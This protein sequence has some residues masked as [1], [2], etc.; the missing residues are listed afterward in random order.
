MTL[1]SPQD[2]ATM[3]ELRGQIDR[4]D[5][6]L[7]R[8]F[9]LR[10]AHVDR[11]VELKLIEGLPA[12]IHER[13]E[14]VVSH[15]SDVAKTEGFDADIAAQMWRLMIEGMIAREEQAMAYNTISSSTETDKNTVD[16]RTSHDC[17]TD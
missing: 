5:H 2:I 14:A 7:I 15:V 13:V 3:A 17:H 6:E 4:L 9:A 1:K 16:K 10:Q 12:R 11:A 8:L